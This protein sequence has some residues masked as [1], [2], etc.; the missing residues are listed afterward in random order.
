MRLE[1]YTVPDCDKD[2][3]DC[4]TVLSTGKLIAARQFNALPASGVKVLRKPPE[5][6]LPRAVS[7]KDVARRTYLRDLFSPGHWPRL[8]ESELAAQVVKI[9][10]RWGNSEFDRILAMTKGR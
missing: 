6:R 3:L 9:R 1:P 4:G 5:P 10:E 8:S 2:L 7:A